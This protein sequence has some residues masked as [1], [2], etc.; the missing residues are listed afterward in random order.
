MCGIAGILAPE[1]RISLDAEIRAMTAAIAHRGP[2]GDGHWV[3]EQVALGHRRLSIIDLA[4]GAQPM[5]DER[6]RVGITYNGEVY[7]YRELRAELEQKGH[8]F[9]TKSDTEVVLRAYIEWGHQSVERLRGMFAFCVTDL[10]R[11]RLFLARDHFGIKPLVYRRGRGLF[12]FA[13][14]I[15]ALTA[16]ALGPLSGDLS[17]VELFLRYQ[18]VPAPRS[19]YREIEKLP[20]AHHLVVDFD[21]KI[22]GPTRYWDFRFE[23]ELG[24]PLDAW[25]DRFEAA[26]QESVKAHL[27]ADVPFGVFLSGGVDSSLVAGSMRDLLGEGV[28]G[29]SIGFDEAR[30]SELEHA[31]SVAER[32]QIDLK[33]EIVRAAELDDLPRM[34]DRVGEPFGD[35]SIL[36]TFAVARLA[37]AHVPMVLSGDGGDELFAGYDTHLAFLRESQLRPY[38]ARL[39]KRPGLD[40]LKRLVTAAVTRAMRHDLRGPDDWE[41]W[42]LYLDEPLRRRL[43]RPELRVETG[44]PSRAFSRAAEAAQGMDRLAFAQYMD[45]QTYLPSDILTKV[46]I[47]TMAVGLESRTPLIDLRVLDLARKIPADLRVERRGDKLFGKQ[48]PRRALHRRLDRSF[49]DRKKQGFGIPRYEWFR[50]GGK[51]RQMLERLLADTTTLDLFDASAIRALFAEQDRGV[52]RD[53]ALFLLL[54]LGLFREKRPGLSFA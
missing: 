34:I 14:E 20:P 7:N 35:S 8:R 17:A 42:V 26:L 18:Y 22:T 11:R 1:Q 46:D 23:P 24:V 29:F 30:V 53:G 51:G 38:L 39:K 16:P 49:V 41:R 48:I 36:P 3:G 33:T 2:D 10:D 25:V 28:R 47:A 13:S 37:R 43:F 32:F 12:S 44:A 6:G 54:V 21:G 19:I 27:V 5:W 40:A 31:R 50:A 52:S 4:G 45:I 9:R 15:A